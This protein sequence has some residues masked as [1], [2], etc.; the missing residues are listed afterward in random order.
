M[1]TFCKA[2]RLIPSTVTRD[3]ARKV[4]QPFKFYFCSRN[5]IPS[6]QHA[7]QGKIHWAR[8]LLTFTRVIFY[9]IH[10]H[11][12]YKKADKDT[13]FDKLI[14]VLAIIYTHHTVFFFP[15]PDISTHI[16]LHHLCCY[17]V[18]QLKARRYNL[19]LHI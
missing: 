10:G 3:D 8:R 2:Y 1:M 19:H 9:R 11:V 14:V 15:F 13:P 17:L 7:R 16:F 18:V 5:I 4:Q 12:F 6:H